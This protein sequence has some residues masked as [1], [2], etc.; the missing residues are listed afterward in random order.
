M[1]FD[2]SNRYFFILTTKMHLQS[3]SLWK[4][5][6]EVC[7]V[8]EG[9]PIGHISKALG[10]WS[11]RQIL[12]ILRIWAKKNYCAVIASHRR[13]NPYACRLLRHFI[14]RNDNLTEDL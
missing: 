9:L 12:G 1:E 13:S 14:P 7:K 5:G 3:L 8:S 10:G 2:K 11:V 4:R 6:R